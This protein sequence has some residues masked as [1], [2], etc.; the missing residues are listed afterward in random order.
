[1]STHAGHT[2]NRPVG[3]CRVLDARWH[4]TTLAEDVAVLVV[5]ALAG[6]VAESLAEAAVWPLALPAE[7][8]AL[9][10]HTAF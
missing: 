1:M 9:Q 4:L 10:E 2:L 6:A 7:A 5:E 3:T 8:L